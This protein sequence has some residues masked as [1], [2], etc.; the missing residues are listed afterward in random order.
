MVSTTLISFDVEATDATDPPPGQ[1]SAEL[2]P[3]VAEGSRS[4]AVA[5][6]RHARPPTYRS[7][8]LTR[9]PSTLAADIFSWLTTWILSAPVEAVASGWF[10]R[11]FAAARGLGVDELLP[12][13]SFGLTRHT[14]ANF[15]GI[16]LVNFFV[17]FDIWASMYGV[18]S[19]FFFTEDEWSYMESEMD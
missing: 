7:T 11:S 18:A 19:L 12:F 3:N 17:Q 13:W 4:D 2:R 10:V 14:L 9:L 8:A 15:A 5:Q 6:S 16:T 1:W